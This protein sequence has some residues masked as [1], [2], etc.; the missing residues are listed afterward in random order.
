MFVVCSRLQIQ[1]HTPLTMDPKG[2]EN[3]QDMA[4]SENKIN[5]YF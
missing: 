1:E 4:T 5:Q 3:T 2:R